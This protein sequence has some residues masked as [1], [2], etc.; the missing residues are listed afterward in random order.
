MPRIVLC[1]APVRASHTTSRPFA[2]P[3]FEEVTSQRPSGVS[4]RPRTPTGMPA[5]GRSVLRPARSGNSA[6]YADS[7]HDVGMPLPL[8]LPVL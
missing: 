8:P 6:V 4:A 5:S 7:G 1:L 3:A 2:P